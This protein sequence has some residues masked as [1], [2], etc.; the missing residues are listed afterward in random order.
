[1]KDNVFSF[2]KKVSKLNK[3]KSKIFKKL[4]KKWVKITVKYPFFYPC[5]EIEKDR[6]YFDDDFDIKDQSIC[7]T[8]QYSGV[9]EEISDKV[10]II[11]KA[12]TI[13]ILPVEFVVSVERFH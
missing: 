8:F 11:Q 5:R 9:V 12:E 10:V 2:E 6:Y 4:L 7:M 1:M 3:R 13:I